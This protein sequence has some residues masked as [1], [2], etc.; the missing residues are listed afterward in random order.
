MIVWGGSDAD[1]NVLN[2]GAR[3]SPTTNVWT[4]VETIGAPSAR[5]GHF[6]FWTGSGMIVWGG[7]DNDGA[8][9]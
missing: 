5:S 8:Y 9:V 2:E 7:E 1:G 6:A 4:P 3:Y